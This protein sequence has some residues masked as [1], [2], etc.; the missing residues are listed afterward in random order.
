V[1]KLTEERFNSPLQQEQQNQANREIS[2]EHDL[3]NIE[4]CIPLDRV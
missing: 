1:E 2:N 4:I 3:G